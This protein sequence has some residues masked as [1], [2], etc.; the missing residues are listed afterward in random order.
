MVEFQFKEI[1][2][3]NNSAWRLRMM[4]DAL[5]WFPKSICTIEGDHIRV[6]DRL[7]E[8]MMENATEEIWPCLKC[9]RSNLIKTSD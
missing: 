5:T 9:G 6:P 4:G 1:V 8:K 3:E 7:V 2:R